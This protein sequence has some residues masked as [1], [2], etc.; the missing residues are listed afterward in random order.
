MAA[1]RFDVRRDVT[2]CHSTRPA[3]VAGEQIDV[4]F[5]DGNI[6]PRVFLFVFDSHLTEGRAESIV[7]V[8]Y[9]LRSDRTLNNLSHDS[10][11]MKISRRNAITML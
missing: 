6:P 7:V 11:H 10:G 5:V 2:R 4:A 3:S 9:N 1:S 8:G